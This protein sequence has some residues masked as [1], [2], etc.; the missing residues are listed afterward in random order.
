MKYSQLCSQTAFHNF[1]N[2][3]D[4]SIL[5]LCSQ[6][7]IDNKQRC[8]IELGGAFSRSVCLCNLNICCFNEHGQVLSILR[9]HSDES[10]KM[11]EH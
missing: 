6:A 2:A 9:C 5:L 8:H 11:V 7:V 10:I 1:L 3:I 4:H